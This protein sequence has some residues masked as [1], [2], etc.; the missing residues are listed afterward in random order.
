V[1]WKRKISSTARY[2]R[3]LRTEARESLTLCRETLL[4]LREEYLKNSSIAIAVAKLLGG[5]RKKGT[6][7]IIPRNRITLG[8]TNRT[9]RVI[10]GRFA[11]AYM[12]NLLNYRPQE[13]VFPESI[14]R[15]ATI[16]P[17]LRFVQVESDLA[18]FP[19]GEQLLPWLLNRYPE[20]DEK[21]ILRIYHEIVR[22]MPE[23]VRQE[24]EEHTQPLY[25][26]TVR[27]YPHT[28]EVLQ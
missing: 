12:A 9:Q 13:T 14:D 23:S 21:E 25:Q 17:R 27:Y 2:L 19:S 15:P 28:I 1:S 5:I 3:T 4:P 16:Q 10:P 22:R 11:K 26:H 8:G 6:S 7:R 18:R 24:N 20:Q